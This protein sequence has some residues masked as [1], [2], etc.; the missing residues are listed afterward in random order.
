MKDIPDLR[1]PRQNLLISF[2]Q[3]RPEKDQALQLK[4]WKKI[5][6]KIPKDSKFWLLGTVRDEDDQRIVDNLKDLAKQLE[7]ENSVEFKIGKSR[8]EIVEIF[9]QAKVAIHTMRN[10]HFG[11]AVVE[12]MASGIVTIAHKS[13]GPLYD[14]IGGTDM[15]VGYLAENENEYAMFVEMAM[16]NFSSPDFL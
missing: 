7:I 12:L 15:P 10:E 4:I 3:F 16:N 8:T 9:S 6:H 13:A 11:I 1:A 5:Q 2:A 14:I